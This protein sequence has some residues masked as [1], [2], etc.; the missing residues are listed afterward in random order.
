MSHSKPGNQRQISKSEKPT[1]NEKS[2]EFANWMCSWSNNQLLWSNESYQN[3]LLTYIG[4]IYAQGPH[5]YRL[6]TQLQKDMVKLDE[7][8][9]LNQLLE[10]TKLLRGAY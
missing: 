4:R 3:A 9:L 10:K 7:L 2:N 6:F 1:I 5:M 8:D